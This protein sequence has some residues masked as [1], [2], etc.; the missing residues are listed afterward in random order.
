MKAV[1]VAL[2]VAVTFLFVLAINDW[3]FAAER[4]HYWCERTYTLM[5]DPDPHEACWQEWA[6]RGDHANLDPTWPHEE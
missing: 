1:L 4:G 3:K 5:G 6:T 2:L